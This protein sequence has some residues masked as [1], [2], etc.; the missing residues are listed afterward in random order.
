MARVMEEE[1][2]G[3]SSFVLTTASPLQAEK[4]GNNI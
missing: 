2:M 3:A 1:R 4:T